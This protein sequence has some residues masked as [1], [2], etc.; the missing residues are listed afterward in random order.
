[1]KK[2]I[3]ISLVA[4]FFIA[5]NASNNSSLILFNKSEQLCGDNS[6]SQQFHKH[7]DEFKKEENEELRRQSRKKVLRQKIKQETEQLKPD[8]KQNE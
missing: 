2:I 1:M 6:P 3:T 5:I 7:N 8:E 4:A